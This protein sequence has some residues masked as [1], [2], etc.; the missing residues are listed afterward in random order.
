MVGI[1]IGFMAIGFGVLGSKYDIFW[2]KYGK[3]MV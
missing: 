3:N 2:T 1:F